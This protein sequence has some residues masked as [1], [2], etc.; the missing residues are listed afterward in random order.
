[1][2][3]STAEALVVAIPLSTANILAGVA[4]IRLISVRRGNFEP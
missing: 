1:M 4:V 3:E 2:V